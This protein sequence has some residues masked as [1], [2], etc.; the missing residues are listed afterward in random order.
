MNLT[1]CVVACALASTVALPAAAHPI[2]YTTTLSGAAES[3]PSGSSGTGTAT[4]TIDTDLFTARV[5]ASFSGLSGTTSMAHIHCCTT[6]AGVSTAGVASQVP[7]YPGFPLGVTS[8]TYDQTFDLTQAASWNPAF[9][10]ANG[11]TTGTAFS[12]LLAGLDAGKAYFNIH[13]SFAGGGEI[14]GF[15]A[16]PEPS[17]LA[18]LGSACAVLAYATRSTRSPSRTRPGS[19]TEA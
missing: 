14:R 12:A 17:G 8:G 11:G 19:R 13:S 18:L 16:V 4:L 1:T 10:T 9:V 6:D 3:P 15:F 5:Q 7:S 2:T